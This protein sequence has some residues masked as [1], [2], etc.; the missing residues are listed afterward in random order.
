MLLPWQHYR[1]ERRFGI[2]RRDRPDL[3][4]GHRGG[5]ELPRR[6]HKRCQCLGSITGWA[7]GFGIRRR[8][9]PDLECGHGEEADCLAGHTSGVS[10]LAVLPDGR[11][12][13]GS[14]DSTIRLW[15][16]ATSE[17]IACLEGH[18]H[19]VHAESY[20][21]QM[22]GW[23]RDQTMEQSCFGMQRQEKKPTALKAI[24]AL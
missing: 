10:A 20:R 17:E 1:R 7:F 16:A 19:T 9:R 15:D 21:C 6:P 23:L 4:C 5:S 2:R 8:D 22:G 3:E 24:V 14:H 18:K 12:A 13:S 11:L